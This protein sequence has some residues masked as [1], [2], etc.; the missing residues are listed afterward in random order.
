MPAKGTGAALYASPQTTGGNM[1]DSKKLKLGEIVFIAVLSSALG[2]VWWGYTFGYKLLDPVT[3]PF[4]LST[5]MEGMWL[6]GGLFFPY[7][8]RKPGSAFFGEF[9]AASVQAAIAGAW[10]AES[11]AYGLVQGLAAEAI[12]ALFRYRSFALPVMMLAGMAAAIPSFFLSF[13][14]YGYWKLE[15][16]YGSHLVYNAVLLGAYLVS[17]CVF[18]FLSKKLA[19][20]LKAAGVLGYFRIARG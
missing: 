3:Q 4:G 8:I 15:G 1:T 14:W 10:G 17:A 6:T 16:F 13:F 5:L 12:F 18:A 19:D 11:L 20:M 7:I 2:I 9:I